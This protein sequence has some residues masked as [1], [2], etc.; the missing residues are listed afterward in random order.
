MLEKDLEKYNQIDLYNRIEIPLLKTLALMENEGINLD[1]K[2]LDKLSEKTKTEVNDLAE[3]IYKE[4]EAEFNISSPKQLG[5][6]L[7]DQMKI[8]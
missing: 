1:I 4:A 8:R 2:F 5:E 7:F 3:K 6:I